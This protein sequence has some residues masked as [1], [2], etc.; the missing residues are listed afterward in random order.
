MKKITK[1]LLIALIRILCYSAL[2][3]ELAVSTKLYLEYD[4]VTRI[5][6]QTLDEGPAIGICLPRLDPS[7]PEKIDLNSIYSY[8]SINTK[9]TTV[10]KNYTLECEK[11]KTE[12]FNCKAF[13][14][15]DVRKNLSLGFAKYNN[16]VHLSLGDRSIQNFKELWRGDD[17]WVDE[18]KYDKRTTFAEFLSSKFQRCFVLNTLYDFDRIK[19][20]ISKTYIGK[21]YRIYIVELDNL[22]YAN[23]D[24]DIQLL[25]HTSTPSKKAVSKINFKVINSLILAN[26][27]ILKIERLPAPYKTD[28]RI[29]QTGNHKL[30]QSSDD[31]L[32]RCIFDAF[33]PSG[34]K[35][36]PSFILSI[37]RNNLREW[38]FN[39]LWLKEFLNNNGN[40]NNYSKYLDKIFLGTSIKGCWT[41]CKID[42]VSATYFLKPAKNELQEPVSTKFR[43]MFNH[44]DDYDVYL[45]HSP[46]MD[47]ISYLGNVGGLAGMWVGFSFS[48]LF[49]SGLKAITSWVTKKAPKTRVSTLNIKLDKIVVRNVKSNDKIEILKKRLNIFI[50]LFAVNIIV[51]YILICSIV[52]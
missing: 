46:L 29:Y 20:L 39:T 35:Y 28:C 33:R 15:C 36:L 8:R 27:H 42:C 10:C 48:N 18:T 11:T 47:W 25:S 32:A 24:I 2:V 50:C 19:K 3:Y 41:D 4:T 45:K 9:N 34:F 30:D 13:K 51:I 37:S 49:I 52:F 1:S 23:D 40:D 16:S 17:V 5:E 38:F 31:C 44:D 6:Y 7:N 26:F 22:V 12:Y 21:N 43:I 14:D